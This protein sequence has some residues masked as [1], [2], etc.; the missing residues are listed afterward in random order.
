M[1]SGSCGALLLA[2]AASSCKL[3]PSTRLKAGNGCDVGERLQRNAQREHAHDLARARSDQHR[4]DECQSA[5]PK[6]HRDRFSSNA[7]TETDD[8]KFLRQV[9]I[10]R[11]HYRPAASPRRMLAQHGNVHQTL[12]SVAANAPVA[13]DGASILRLIPPVVMGESVLRTTQRCRRYVRLIDLTRHVWFDVFQENSIITH[14]RPGSVFEQIKF[15]GPLTDP[16]KYGGPGRGCLRRRDSVPARLRLSERPTQAGWGLDRIGSPWAILMK[17]LGYTHYV[18][19]GGDGGGRR[20]GNGPTGA[21][22][23]A[24]H[25]NTGLSVES[26]SAR[27]G[28][29]SYDLAEPGRPPR[30]IL[31]RRNPMAAAVCKLGQI[32]VS[33]RVRLRGLS[34]SVSQFGFDGSATSR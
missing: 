1:T 30:S 11:D 3:P 5:I 6:A 27:E 17:R 4:A 8:V 16:T 33:D 23:P 29:T 21:S 7:S 12:V 18:A 24:R 20:R 15:I 9:R 19:Q 13:Y 34:Q 28:R 26:R 2:F 25:P 31:E 32:A 22:G 14:G 10:P